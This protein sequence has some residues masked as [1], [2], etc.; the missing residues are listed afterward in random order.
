[1]LVVIGP[2]WLSIGQDGKRRIDDPGDY[3]AM[4]I[5]AALRRSIPILL[6]VTDRGNPRLTRYGRVLVNVRGAE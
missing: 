4:E 5:A 3:V 1:M 2:A 6:S